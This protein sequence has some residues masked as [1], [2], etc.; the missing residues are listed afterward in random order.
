MIYL[1]S[2][3]THVDKS[4]QES[5]YQLTMDAL[6]VFLAQGEFVYSP[7]VHCHEMAKKHAMPTDYKFWWDYNVDFID[8]SNG[9]Y[10]LCIDGWLE[11]KGLKKEVEYSENCPFLPKFWEFKNGKWQVRNYIQS[12]QELGL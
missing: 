2:P 7:I 1:A 10:V 8:N 12:F 11:S 6:A 4:V 5:R 3:Y 9:L